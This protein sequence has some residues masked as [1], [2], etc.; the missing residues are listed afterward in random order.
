MT[1]IGGKK[2]DARPVKDVPSFANSQELT[3]SAFYPGAKAAFKNKFVLFGQNPPGQQEKHKLF[4]NAYK[5]RR[6]GLL[7]R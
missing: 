4:L 1:R 6:V 2:Q 5:G 3:A 7:A